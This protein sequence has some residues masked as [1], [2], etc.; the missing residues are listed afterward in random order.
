M[1]EEIL[2]RIEQRLKVVGLSA[3]GAAE[4][5]GLS[6]DVIRN[7]RRVVHGNLR[8]QKGVNSAT[9][10]ALAPILR[11]TP[12]WLLEG[13]GDEDL[14]ANMVPVVGWVGADSDGRVIYTTGQGTGDLAP[15]PPGGTEAA[16]AL[17]V[18]G[19]SMPGLAEE[20]ALIYFEDQHRP[21]TPEMLG[22][23]VIVETTLGEILVKRLLRGAR[24]G[25]Y[26]LESLYGPTLTDREIVWAAHITA[27]IP[28]RQAR[29]IIVSAVA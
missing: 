6:P 16:R 3:S 25:L 24:P 14:G 21:P 2:A 26:D 19:G 1:L 5:A 13:V 17:L 7:M 18:K 4:K 9:L 11:T 27:I 12:S 10:Y 8:D 22:Y 23:T 29:K 28:P 20:G 15:I